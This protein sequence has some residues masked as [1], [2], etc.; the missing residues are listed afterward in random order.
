MKLR[1][2]TKNE[3][4]KIVLDIVYKLKRFQANNDVGYID[5][6]NME[7]EAMRK[8]KSVFD[9]YIS[10][11]PSTEISGKIYFGELNRTIHYVLPSNERRMPIFKMTMMY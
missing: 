3:R 7:Y 10:S 8:L 2:L 5:I 1:S 11:E 9:E 6:Y 4:V